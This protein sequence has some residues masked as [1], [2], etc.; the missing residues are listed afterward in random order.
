MEECWKATFLRMSKLI[1]EVE[2]SGG[3]LESDFSEDVSAN[4]GGEPRT[5]SELWPPGVQEN[6]LI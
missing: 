1:W 5:R 4:L 3:K 2:G 6:T